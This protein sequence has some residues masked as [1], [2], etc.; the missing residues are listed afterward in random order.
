MK[1]L[2]FLLAAGSLTIG[3]AQAGTVVLTPDEVATGVEI[4]AAIAKATTHGTEPGRVVFD[5]QHKGFSCQVNEENPEVSELTFIQYSNLQLVGIN[6]ANMGDGICNVVL[7]DAPL[8]NILIEE[9]KIASFIEEGTGISARGLSPRNNV[10]IRN[11]DISGAIAIQAFNP[12]GWKIHKNTIGRA[13]DTV[14]MLFGAQDSAIIGNTITGE[15]GILLAPSDTQDTTG[16]KIIANRFSGVDGIE[17]RRTGSHNLVALNTG[18]CPV[19]LL[20]SGSTL[21]TVL[22]NRAPSAS[23][24]DYGAVQDLGSGNRLFGNRP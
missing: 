22:F 12:V 18:N 24:G 16:N 10:T 4:N 15:P 20:D 11:S 5:G 8:E 13:R 2:P 7:A 9:L 1:A 19:V 6:G 3:A 21:N 23:C 17:L 14:I